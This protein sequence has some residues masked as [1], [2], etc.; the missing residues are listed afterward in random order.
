MFLKRNKQIVKATAARPTLLPCTA[1]PKV[2]AAAAAAAVL[3][4]YAPVVARTRAAA[5]SHSTAEKH[6][7]GRALLGG[8][9]ALKWRWTVEQGEDGEAELE[10][11][12]TQ[13]GKVHT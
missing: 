2:D 6:H 7:V 1:G 9:Q 12:K 3:V 13:P 4:F 8:L 10:L 11:L 5:G